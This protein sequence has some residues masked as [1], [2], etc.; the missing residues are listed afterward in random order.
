MASQQAGL[1]KL[2]NSCPIQILP[3]S[4]GNL[5]RTVNVPLQLLNSSS[6]L[7][8]AT[9]MRT[10]GGTLVSDH[11]SGLPLQLSTSS[12][13]IHNV[14]NLSQKTPSISSSTLLPV[15]LSNLRS[16]NSI[17]QL[18]MTNQNSNRLD[19]H[20]ASSDMEKLGQST[21]RNLNSTLQKHDPQSNSS[22]Q[23]KI[24]DNQLQ[25]PGTQFQLKIPN[26]NS[27]NSVQ[28][29][30]A[31]PG[32]P[33][34]V[35]TGARQLQ[36]VLYI[37]TPTGLKQATESQMNTS[38]SSHSQII[39]RRSQTS[40]SMQLNPRQIV[41]VSTNKSTP[42]SKCS[43][44]APKVVIQKSNK[45]TQVPMNIPSLT[46]GK[47]I[48]A[49]MSG[50]N[51]L[52]AYVNSMKK[53]NL[54]TSQD[55]QQSLLTSSSH[56][57]VPTSTN[58]KLLVTSMNLSKMPNTKFYVPMAVPASM[59]AKGP[60]INFQIANGQ[61]QN[62]PQGKITVMGDSVPNAIADVPPLQPFSKNTTISSSSLLTSNA[63]TQKNNSNSDHA[64]PGT[65]VEPI[66]EQEYTLSIPESDASMNDD[67]YTVSI[68]D[69]NDINT[70]VEKSFT[71]PIPDK[72]KSLLNKMNSGMDMS[73]GMNLS[74]SA[75]G[76]AILRRSN[77]DS[78]EKKANNAKRRISLCADTLIENINAKVEIIKNDNYS[79]N[80][81][82]TNEKSRVPSLFCDE[83]L[84]DVES[85]PNQLQI[86]NHINKDR[87]KSR[88][89][90]DFHHSLET[91]SEKNTDNGN[92]LAKHEKGTQKQPKDKLVLDYVLDDAPGLQWNNGVAMLNGSSLQFHLNEFGVI[93]IMDA[94][95]KLNTTKRGAGLNGRAKKSMSP[96]ELYCC[97][98][99]GCH[100]MAAEFVTS[101]FCS[102]TCQKAYEKSLRYKKDRQPV[103]FRKKRKPKK[104]ITQKRIG[105]DAELVINEDDVDDFEDL[106]QSEKK[107]PKLEEIEDNYAKV[108][109]EPVPNKNPWL[110]NKSG[111]SWMR[112]LEHCKAIAAPAKFFKDP[113]Q[114][115]NF[116]KGM[117]LEAID[118][119]H[120]SIYS[121]VTVTEIQGHRLRLHF[122]GYHEDYDFWVNVDSSDIF[123]PGWCEK[124]K[125]NLR[126]PMGFD[127][128]DFSWPLYIKQSKATA[129]PK[130][131]FSHLLENNCPTGFRPGMKLEAEDRKNSL[132]C[133]ASVADI[134]NN[135]VLIHFDS[136]DDIYDYW[137]DPT[138]PY[139]H[140]VGWCDDNG[141]SLTPPNFYKDPENF[142]WEQ[143]LTETEAVAV[144]ARAF[145]PR[146]PHRFK[147]GMKLEAVDKRA[148]FLIRAAS[149]TDVRC[150][151]IR[152]SFDGWP[153]ELSY[154]VDDDSPDIHPVGWC[155]KTGHL[156]EPPLTPED[157]QKP[158]DC[159]TAG[160]RG[161]GNSC[162]AKLSTHNTLAECP[163]RLPAVSP[164][165]RDRLD[166]ARPP[167]QL[168]EPR[169]RE[170]RK[171]NNSS[172][173]KE[174][175]TELHDKHVEDMSQMD[176]EPL[177][178]EISPP[179]RKQ[180]DEIKSE[181]ASDE[182]SSSQSKRKRDVS[183]RDKE[184]IESS[185][186]YPPYLPNPNRV[187]PPLWS[188]EFF[189]VNDILQNESLRVDPR[190][191][192]Q[193]EV[194]RFVQQIA[195]CG[196][197]SWKFS[198]HRIDGESFLMMSQ[199]DLVSVIGMKLGPA[200]KVYNSIIQLRQKIL[201]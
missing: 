61:L 103:D 105:K 95:K 18:Q 135:R 9:S 97:D 3:V 66:N 6:S 26:S 198:K 146:P 49:Y 37:Q 110:C 163:Y 10:S 130:N 171:I 200:I 184:K 64:I 47:N 79:E 150:H 145:K 73:Q 124:N 39:V 159:G 78:N 117:K 92:S 2:P 189:S 75:H 152:I 44:L 149:I 19:K 155:L 164:V 87:R 160:C 114:K 4:T 67:V 32:N 74:A 107:A 84:D 128:S 183:P 182:E 88:V 13:N 21:M 177:S 94:E 25:L 134:V 30:M 199:E 91:I 89:S 106:K 100:G 51:T 85:K 93:D 156:L 70:S 167:P 154:W 35:R 140:P 133:V 99:C 187:A 98:E 38:T 90:S 120:P 144:P 101:N 62:D 54:P 191:W 196:E 102:R 29:Q 125:R 20:I 139:I 45:L 69:S 181:M 5:P 122:D 83:E 104:P 12:L 71:I 57:S 65:R 127:S 168:S 50:K 166:G 46:G 53:S 173:P 58:Q 63:P 119:I 142:T 147:I 96:D 33:V 193:S 170:P 197:F 24:Q 192:N 22:L 8:L 118:P 137:V 16:P 161:L 28:L 186:Y 34:Q 111:F 23:A 43:I 172:K 52:S 143:Y 201:S 76:P 40:S 158:S 148:P 136:W 15:Q 60:V 151:Q 188:S 157:F 123:P 195:K 112:Y 86:I 190:N 121:V 175:L 131:L 138:S 129:A 17:I 81:K 56:L 178:Y 77:S 48:S 132:T 31:H 165:F 113:H 80:S 55:N 42:V 72:G 126:L 194:Q 169:T 7:N 41:N 27:G 179:K 68:S 185:V 174:M 162:S 176:E 180:E 36:P 82:A 141:Y 11:A 1:T 109:D 59:S 116:K 153:D 108:A 14:S 115:N